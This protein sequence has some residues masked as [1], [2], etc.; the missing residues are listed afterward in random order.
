MVGTNPIFLP[1]DFNWLEIERISFAEETVLIS[2]SG[3]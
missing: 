3:H 1:L 2:A